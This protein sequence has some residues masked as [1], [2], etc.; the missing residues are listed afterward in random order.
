MILKCGLHAG[1]RESGTVSLLD[2]T[3]KAGE[4]VEAAT[5]IVAIRSM[6]LS[7]ES[8]IG[9]VDPAGRRQ[10]IVSMDYLRMLVRIGNE[11]F[12]ENGKRIARFLG[13]LR[14]EVQKQES[15]QG[16]GNRKS[17]KERR[18]EKKMAEG[19]RRQAEARRLKEQEVVEDLAGRIEDEMGLI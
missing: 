7:F 10:A 17:E 19:L 9:M 3:T 5:P 13:A 15:G 8:L 2:N 18:R 1:F 6:G 11:R 4:V 16:E 14:S 12:A